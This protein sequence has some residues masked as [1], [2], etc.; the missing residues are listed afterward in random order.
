[1]TCLFCFSTLSLMTC[2]F[3][4]AT[5]HSWLLYFVSATCHSVISSHTTPKSCQKKTSSQVNNWSDNTDESWRHEAQYAYFRQH[6]SASGIYWLIPFP[7]TDVYHLF[8]SSNFSHSFSTCLVVCEG[9][10]LPV[11][12]SSSGF[13]LLQPNYCRD[14]CHCSKTPLLHVG[15]REG[16]T[17]T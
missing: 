12:S 3:F 11:L 8:T 17:N 16:D 9:D 1:M 2:L 5:C 15:V 4:S 7:F 6:G 13:F 14:S 10:H